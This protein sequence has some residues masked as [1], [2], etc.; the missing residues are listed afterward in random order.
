MNVQLRMLS[1]RFS[2]ENVSELLDKCEGAIADEK[3]TQDEAKHICNWIRQH[4]DL[5]NVWPASLL[6]VK[7]SSLLEKKE[8]VEEEKK[9]VLELLKQFTGRHE[10]VPFGFRAPSPFP[11]D[12]P[13][14]TIRFVARNFCLTGIFALGDRQTCAQEIVSLGGTVKKSMSALVDYLVIG[15]LANPEWKF[16][17]HG[18]KIEY[19]MNLKKEGHETAIIGEDMWIQAILNKQMTERNSNSV[20]EIF[21]PECIH[22]LSRE[23]TA[24]K[25]WVWTLRAEVEGF[26]IK[27]D[28]NLKAKKQRVLVDRA[29]IDLDIK[30]GEM[31]ISR[32]RY[33]GMANAILQWIQGEYA[34][35]KNV[36]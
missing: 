5:K 22:V 6:Y 8:F 18:R 24:S 29:F 1:G 21:L 12:D 3:V 7:L 2:S 33:E 20:D 10:A 19:A 27:T 36:M 16:A 35:L 28:L 15:S 30:S 26:Q 13:P 23:Q 9:D 25:P 14:P 11:L 32:K 34:E 31:Y 4:D 17:T